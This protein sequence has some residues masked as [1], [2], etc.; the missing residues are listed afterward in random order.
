MNTLVIDNL[1]RHL[2]LFGEI[3]ILCIDNKKKR[4]IEK[5]IADL[6][7]KPIRVELLK[8]YFISL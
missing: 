1:E 3:L 5:K 4:E 8:E 2:K 7:L 6:I